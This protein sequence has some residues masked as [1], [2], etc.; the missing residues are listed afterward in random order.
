MRPKGFLIYMFLVQLD[1]GHS[2]LLWRLYTLLCRSYTSLCKLY[3][4]PWKFHKLIET[5]CKGESS[6]S[7]L[8]AIYG[9]N[10]VLAG[11][12]TI[13]SDSMSE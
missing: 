9:A 7:L 11:A 5:L 1:C 8:R 13:Q 12:L 4:L 6:Y 10:N 2:T 3:T